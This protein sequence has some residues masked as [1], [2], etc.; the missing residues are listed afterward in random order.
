MKHWN[1]FKEEIANAASGGTPT[2][3]G[4]AGLGSPPN[5]EPVVKKKKKNDMHN[6]F[7]GRTKQFKEKVRSLKSNREKRETL[8]LEKK[9]GIKLRGF[10]N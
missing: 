2:G 3:G 6:R 1:E 4:I 10:Q 9:Y 8:K 5:D 7:D